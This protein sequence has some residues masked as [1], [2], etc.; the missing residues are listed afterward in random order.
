[1]AVFAAVIGLQVLVA[2]LSIDLLSAVRAYVTGESL[3]SKGQKDAQIYLLDYADFQK[4]EDYQR[5]LRALELPLGDRA[6]REELQKPQPDL[7]RVRQGFLAGGNHPD[8]IDGL[9]RLF[10]WFHRVPFMAAAIQT[11][12]EGDS[13]IEQMRVLVERA[14]E[15]VKAGTLDA[16]A[17]R[18]MRMQAL[19]LNQRMTELE[20]RFSE[21]LG[22]A[23]RQTKGLLLGLNLSFAA[24]LSLAGMRFVRQSL[25]ERALAEAE[26]RRRQESLQRMLDSA[27]EG[28]YGVDTEGKCTFVNRS[29]LAMLGYEQESDLVGRNIH[30]LIHHTYPDGR[31]YPARDCKLSRAERQGQH[32]HVVDEV[33]WRRDGRSFPVECWSHPVVQDGQVQGM[34]VTFFDITERVRAQA[35][36]RESEARLSR[37]VDSVA[38][39]VITIDARERVILF[40]RAAEKLFR[41]RAAEI[42]GRPLERLIPER[43][44]PRHHAGVQ[45]FARGEA[46]NRIVNGLHELVGLRANGE[47]FPIEASLSKLETEQGLLMTVVLRDVS[48]QRAT[49]KERQARE[50]LEASNRAKTQFLSRMSHELRT[51]LNAVLGFAQL[52]R[53]DRAHTLATDQ[54]ARVH[55]IEHAG[56]H[57]LA[58][59]NDVLDLSRVESGQMSLSVEPVD[60]SAVAEEAI[61]LVSPLAAE[62]GVKV[63]SSSSPRQGAQASMTGA[64]E[65]ATAAADEYWVL[66]DRVRLRQVLVNLL[67]NAVKYNRPGG[68]VMLSH[69]RSS[70]WCQIVVADTGKG[71]TAEQVNRLYEPFN[72]LGAELSGIE[73]TGI[74]LVLTR[75][76]VELMGGDI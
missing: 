11:W 52:M 62:V 67:N 64:D 33:F 72:R 3:Y 39:G 20:R 15:Q 61:A 50:E 68:Q 18:E 45:Q 54:L 74:G 65:Q 6:A 13:V 30:A 10:N 48:E 41:V 58:L 46:E 44:R 49:L 8:D 25:R 32:A 31:P 55:H 2:A 51:P 37:L 42:V 57:L 1:M 23:S 29:A 60:A 4:E 38:D 21:Q 19:G 36:L 27:A 17:A 12:T 76:L 59:V 66:A 7:G 34:V 14:R 28:L 75:H 56:N 26:V 71:M 5:F 9:I 70:G 40:N 53:M 47:E 69:E 22:A 16:Q 73:G 35:A 43:L 24:L 63:G